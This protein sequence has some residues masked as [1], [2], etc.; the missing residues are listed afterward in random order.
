MS[1]WLSDLFR[2][3]RMRFC[4]SHWPSRPRIRVSS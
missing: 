3:R 1:F 4:S 2:P